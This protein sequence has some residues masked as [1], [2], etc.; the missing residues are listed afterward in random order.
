MI[1]I[2][3]FQIVEKEQIQFLKFPKEDVLFEEKAKKNRF[4]EL[5]RAMYLG[6]LEREKVKI[7]FKDDCG[8]KRVETTIWAVTDKSVILKKSTIIP[9][10]RI[11]SVA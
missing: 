9:L 3:K 4:L 2:L 7:T 5:R 11:V 10:T 6:N 1:S 8:T